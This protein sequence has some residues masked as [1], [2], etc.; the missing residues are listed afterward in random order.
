MYFQ[1]A[2][3]VTNVKVI[4]STDLERSFI[5][6]GGYEKGNWKDGEM[7]GYGKQ[8]FGSTSRFAGD[9]YEGGFGEGGYSGYGSYH[10]KNED[11]THVGYWKKGK[12]EGYGVE[13]CGENSIC[14]NRCYEGWWK[15]GK[16]NGYGVL[17]SE[18][19]AA[20]PGIKYVGYWLNGGMEGTGIYS[21]SDG[22][23]YEGHFSNDLFDGKAT[24]I[25][26]T[27]LSITEHAM[28]ALI[29]TF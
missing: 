29:L 19:K 18:T 17:H 15:N 9:T 1:V 10:G 28:K 8:Y 26:A 11:F 14:P 2:M 13:K 24:F 16:Y 6:M 4:A 27:D 7:I 22:S 20:N 3:I 12:A 23:R 5:K 25:F 21:W